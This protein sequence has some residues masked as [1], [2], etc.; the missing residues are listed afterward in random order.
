MWVLFQDS[1]TTRILLKLVISSL[2]LP[3]M[4]SIQLQG[5]DVIVGCNGYAFALGVENAEVAQGEGEEEGERS[6]SD[7]FWKH[8]N[9]LTEPTLALQ[10]KWQRDLA[11]TRYQCVSIL[12]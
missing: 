2:F 7:A 12:R 8:S 6:G 5:D 11:G 10:L 3:G 9:V 1:N 4:V